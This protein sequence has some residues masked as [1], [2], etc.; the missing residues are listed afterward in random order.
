MN[1]QLWT[2]TKSLRCSSF[3]L[4]KRRTPLTSCHE[5]IG[6]NPVSHGTLK[7]VV[8]NAS[9]TRDTLRY[10]AGIHRDKNLSRCSLITSWKTCHAWYY[11]MSRRRNTK[12]LRCYQKLSR[13]SLINSWKNVTRFITRCHAFITHKSYNVSRNR[14][15]KLM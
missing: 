7:T 1:Q 9:F 14:Y 13:Y 8:I 4:E 6:P 3:V 11:Q 10:H 2:G 5:K 12:I 15:G